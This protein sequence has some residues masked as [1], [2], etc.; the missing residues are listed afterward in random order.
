MNVYYCVYLFNKQSFVR[1][2]Q[3]LIISTSFNLI[4]SVRKL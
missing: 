1:L 4:S 3:I 2:K